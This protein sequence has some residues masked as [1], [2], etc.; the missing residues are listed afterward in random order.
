MSG[1]RTLAYLTLSLLPRFGGSLIRKLVEYFGSAEAVLGAA[2]KEYVKVPGIGKQL[3][4]TLDDRRVVDKAETIAEQELKRAGELGV[5][6]L[7]PE[8]DYYPT[9]LRTIH[10]PPILLYCKGNKALL[11]QS[12]VAIVGSRA[13]TSY[14][15]RTSFNLA[16][17]LADRGVTVISGM[18]L[19]IDG[20]AHL[21]VLE[22][23]GATIGV[24]GCGL[25]VVYPRQHARLYQEVANRG[26]LVSEYPLQTQPDGFRFPARNRIISGLSLGVVVVEA[27]LRSGS[28]I[29]ARL[30][31]EQ[32]R[33]V[34]AVPGRVDSARSEGTH[35]LLQQGAK[36]V[37]SVDDI[38]EELQIAASLNTA[39]SVNN[40]SDKY[41]GLSAG[42]KK[43]LDVLDVYGRTIDEIIND[44]GFPAAEISDLLFRLEL[45][46]AVRQLP[47]Q[48]Y[49]RKDKN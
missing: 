26:L 25:E 20:E 29:T 13:A 4:A 43:V 42:E 44:T 47:G 23:D 6:V 33:E 19:G 48:Q 36:L 24:L 34:F 46:G 22:R 16:R 39:S 7:D 1:R 37:H 27:T 2:G 5:T 41:N 18:A 40:I 30:A 35:R 15:H 10:D 38:L 3:A 32:G 11:K 31:L 17:A 12:S 28:L 14:G 49:E 9:L 45:K 21:G 8:D